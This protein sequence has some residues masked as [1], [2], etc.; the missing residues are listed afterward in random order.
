MVPKTGLVVALVLAVHPA[1]AAEEQFGEVHFPISCGEDAQR[2]FE[3]GV[4]MVH[5]FD[6]PATIAAFT[7]LTKTAPHCAMAYWGLAISLRPNPLVKPLPVALLKRGA[8][9]IQKARLAATQT[10]RERQWIEALGLYFADYATVPQ[11]QRTLAYE[12]A[13]ARLREQYPDDVEAAVFYALALNEAADLDDKTYARQLKSVAI[14][15][16]LEKQHPNH[17][18]IVHYLIHAYDFAPLAERGLPAARRYAELAPSAAHALHMPSH[19]FSQLGLWQDVIRAD[20]AAD[21]FTVGQA[22]AENSAID[23]AALSWRYH[24]LDFLVNAYLQLAQDRRAEVILEAR[25]RVGALPAD[26]RYTTHT[27]FAAIP[28]R[29]AFER[30]AWA[31]AAQLPVAA[32]PYALAEAVTRFGRA[33]GA[34]RSG[35][36]AAATAETTRLRALADTLARANDPYWARQVEIEGTAAAAWTALAEGRSDAA[37]AAMREAAD[38]ED[39]TEKHVAMENRLSPMRELLGEMLLETGDNAG[40]LAAFATS[41]KA[42]P[43]RLRSFAG[44]ARAA[45]ALGDRGTARRYAEALLA[46]TAAADTERPEMVRARALLAAN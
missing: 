16:P 9:A 18:G 21:D 12:A 36:E 41:L 42:A 20:T 3:R 35:D 28:V 32:T 44:A 25:N 8:E 17:P 5:S 23:V 40:A 13:M 4:A 14:L 34:A 7:A 31:E 15:E 1:L 22:R 27:G 29:Y 26:A 11:E 37:L 43:N 30:G 38:L 2:Q 10:P 45:D 46:Q 24:S 39:A 6:Y 33:I 19:I